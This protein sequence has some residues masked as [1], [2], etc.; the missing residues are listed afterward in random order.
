MIDPQ[1]LVVP[2]QL[3]KLLLQKEMKR[4]KKNRPENLCFWKQIDVASENASNQT[5]VVA[6]NDTF[7]M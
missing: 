6:Q 7:N 1:V 3:S 4:N 2:A 5:T